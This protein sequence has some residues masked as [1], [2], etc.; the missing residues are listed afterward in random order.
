[1]LN[2]MKKSA[3]FSPPYGDGTMNCT[4][5]AIN[6]VFSPPYGDGTWLAL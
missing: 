1:M 3:P 4:P 6:F 5:H 2:L